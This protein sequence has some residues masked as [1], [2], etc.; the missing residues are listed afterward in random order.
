MGI[1]LIGY[2]H[3]G[4]VSRRH[5]VPSVL[6]GD[7][8]KPRVKVRARVKARHRIPDLRSGAHSK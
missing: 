3:C 7:R 1:G 6:V 4:L 5:R 8:V 2:V